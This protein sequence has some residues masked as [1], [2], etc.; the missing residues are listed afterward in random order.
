MEA[1][2]MSA[3]KN[4]RFDLREAK[5][6]E[7]GFTYKTHRVTGWRADGTRVRE[8]FKSRDQAQGRKL[9]L[10]VEAANTGDIAARNTRL[11]PQQLA[12]AE[13]AF[14]RLGERSLSTAVA[15][16][17]DTY[18][19]PLTEM[20]LEEAETVFLADREQ[21]VSEM[22]L[23][24][25]SLTLRV[26]RAAVRAKLVHQVNSADV[27]EF[28]TARKVGKK[29]WNNLRGDLNA[30][31]EFSKAAP[32]QWTTAN[33][34]ASIAK[35]KLTRGV[36]HIET[37]VRIRELFQFLESYTGPESLQHKPGFLVPYFALATFA[38]IR[39]S[40]AEGELWRLGE[41]ELAALVRMIDL[42][43]NV[44][45]LAPE[46]TKTGGVRQVRIRPNLKQWLVRYPLAEFPLYVR[47]M[48]K[49]VGIVRKRFALKDDVLRH[50]F[51]SMHVARWKSVGEAA[52]EA[53]N[54]EA[55]IKAHY[56][57]V[58]S[59]RESKEFWDIRPAA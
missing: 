24:D 28:L 35:F 12:E 21:H 39:P 5:V 10:E 13:A 45:R 20:G 41:L 7:R 25:Y 55:M 23:R 34:V 30:F 46:V 49:I 8:Q 4:G 18:R 53:G 11:T 17:L 33:P 16:F 40:V 43:L 3:T 31:F 54:S 42:E 48:E 32:R 15:W 44:I 1:L 47:N 22:T 2:V 56:L 59:L 50:T 26:F 58:V 27:V 14:A 9:L 19:P 37:A 57:N 29:R 51:I 36:P 38:G 6:T 52:L